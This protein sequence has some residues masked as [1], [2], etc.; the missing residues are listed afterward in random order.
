MKTPMAL[1]LLLG[2][3]GAAHAQEAPVQAASDTGTATPAAGDTVVTG[4]TV[5]RDSVGNTV[6]VSSQQPV[7]P[8]HDY[9][10]K[11]DAMDSND[12]GSLSRTEAGADKY[13]TR[14]FASY[15]SDRNDRLSFEEARR[16]LED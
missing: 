2:L 3:A 16:W 11:F 9:R 14:A 8:A 10:A 6:F 15:D 12:D 4:Q 7:P 5:T 13:L 1:L